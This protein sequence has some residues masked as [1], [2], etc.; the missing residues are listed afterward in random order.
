MLGVNLQ[1]GDSC[2]YRPKSP[3]CKMSR[4]GRR[5]LDFPP[6]TEVMGRHTVASWD[7]KETQPKLYVRKHCPR[8]SSHIAMGKSTML[9][10]SSQKNQEVTGYSH[11][12]FYGTPPKFNMEPEN[13][14]FQKESPFPGTSFQVP[15]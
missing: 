7:I 1:M 2:L 9:L 12:H 4:L 15:C 14:G 10:A 11:I 6:F 5:G 13:D 8:F 3:R